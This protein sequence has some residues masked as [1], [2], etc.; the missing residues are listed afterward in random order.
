MSRDYVLRPFGTT[1]QLNIDYANELN[2]QQFAA[3]TAPPGPSL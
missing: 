1:V 2:E 3:V